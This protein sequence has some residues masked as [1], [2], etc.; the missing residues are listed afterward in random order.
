M[1]AR[2][3][4]AFGHTLK[5]TPSHL[6]HQSVTRQQTYLDI[7]F[8]QCL[9]SVGETHFL[10]LFA[11]SPASMYFVLVSYYLLVLF[12]KVLT[13]HILAHTSVCHCIIFVLHFRC[14]SVTLCNHVKLV[15]VEHVHAELLLSLRHD[16]KPNHGKNQLCKYVNCDFLIY[17]NIY[18]PLDR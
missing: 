5:H 13:Q 11:C 9:H 10:W 15:E 16:C 3:R 4:C 6:T 18:S 12:T 17:T 2:V 8:R 14:V 1:D 7:A